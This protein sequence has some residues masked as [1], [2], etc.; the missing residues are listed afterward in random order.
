MRPQDFTAIERAIQ[1][2]VG[3]ISSSL[4]KGPFGAGIVL[5]LHRSEARDDITRRAKL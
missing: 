3:G 2:R 1:L 4:C 5:S